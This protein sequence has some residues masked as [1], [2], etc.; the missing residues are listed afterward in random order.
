VGTAAV[1]LGSHVGIEVW[2]VDGGAEPLL[3]NGAG[4]CEAAVLAGPAGL[5]RAAA[6]ERVGENRELDE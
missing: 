4:V 6:G 3:R 5:C 2:I 1:N